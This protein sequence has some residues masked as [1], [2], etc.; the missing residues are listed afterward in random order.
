MASPGGPQGA[1]SSMPACGG[2]AGALLGPRRRRW[3][4]WQRSWSGRTA[5]QPLQPP[6]PACMMRCSAAGAPRG[7]PAAQL[8]RTILQQR[9]ALA[10]SPAARHC[11]APPL[12]C[13][14]ASPPPPCRPP[15]CCLLCSR[16]SKRVKLVRDI[17]REV[18][19]QAPYEKRIMELLKVR[20]GGSLNNA[21]AI[22]GAGPHITRRLFAAPPAGM[23]RQRAAVCVA[24]AAGTAAALRCR[25]SGACSL[26]SSRELLHCFTAVFHCL[27]AGWQGQARPEGGQAEGEAR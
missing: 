5:P 18:A 12:A 24:L 23:D 27:P 1:C 25:T 2:P 13:R 26:C 19:G 17:V 11:L 7:L 3:T 22:G 8:C 9:A 10:A 15:P 14:P 6:L 4:A 16:L 20:Q 21:C